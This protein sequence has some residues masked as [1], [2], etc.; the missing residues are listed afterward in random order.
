MEGCVEN[1]TIQ[2][3]FP[4]VESLRKDAAKP[5][6]MNMT[7]AQIAE[8]TLSQLTMRQI[9]KN[10][11]DKFGD[12]HRM[13][14]GRD[15]Q[16]RHDDSIQFLQAIRQ[17][18]SAQ[19]QSE[20]RYLDMRNC[21]KPQQPSL[22]IEEHEAKDTQLMN[23]RLKHAYKEVD[24]IQKYSGKP[25]DKCKINSCFIVFENREDQ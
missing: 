21:K 24:M 8:L 5:N 3:I 2:V 25:F 6:L 13:Y 18:Y 19:L 11:S 20:Q 15:Y 12:I 7:H 23:S 17:E 1:H 14:F 22:T 4:G 10:F 9:H 16:H